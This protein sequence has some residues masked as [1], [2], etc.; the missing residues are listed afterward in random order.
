MTSK[1]ANAKK[2]KN[3]NN[4]HQWW[5]QMFSIC[6]NTWHHEEIIKNLGGI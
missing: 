4:Y 3:S 5:W 2:H 1:N 6:Y